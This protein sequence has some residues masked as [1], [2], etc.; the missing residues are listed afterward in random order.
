MAALS[1][2]L[3]AVVTE[4]GQVRTNLAAMEAELRELRAGG[5]RAPRR[6]VWGPPLVPDVRSP[7]PRR[8]ASASPA[9]RE[10]APV[11]TGQQGMRAGPAP[12][13]PPTPQAI[14]RDD[15][16]HQI[17]GTSLGL[18]AYG[19]DDGDEREEQ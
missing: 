10:P 14:G 18:E 12:P 7:S 6:P 17:P 8:G 16:P 19:S 5:A 11:A 2:E 15:E 3:R 4:L 13:V 9:G 1:G